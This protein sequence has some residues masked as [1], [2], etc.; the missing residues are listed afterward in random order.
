M[1]YSE[2]SSFVYTAETENADFVAV[3][4]NKN[5]KADADDIKA[6]ANTI[7]KKN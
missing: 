6:V 4:L 1:K 2:S 5:G 7:M 3:Y